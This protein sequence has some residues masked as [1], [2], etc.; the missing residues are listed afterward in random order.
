MQAFEKWTLEAIRSEGTA[1]NWIEEQRYEWT[2]TMQ[3]TV[4]QILSGKTMVL[5]TDRKRKWFQHY[6]ASRLNQLSNDRPMIPLISLDRIYPDF[7]E[8][9]SGAAMDMLSDMLD[10]SF[11]GNY[12]FWYVGKGNDPRSEIV[13][14][15][16]NSALWLLDEDFGRA[17][18]LRSFDPYLDIKMLQLYH[19][20]ERSLNAMLFGEID[21]ET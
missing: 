17:M 19:L 2:A 12:F 1:F 20:F 6:I 10:L 18:K 4:T 14:R 9:T 5:V 13:K 7:D 8:M 3:V 16:E 21:A 15:N 11:S